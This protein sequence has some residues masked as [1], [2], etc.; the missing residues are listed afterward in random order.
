MESLLKPLEAS[1]LITSMR[2]ANDGRPGYDFCTDTGLTICYD[3][4]IRPGTLGGPDHRLPETGV[5]CAHQN[6]A[7][8]AF[9]G[10]LL[11][12]I[13]C[14][15]NDDDPIGMLHWPAGLCWCGEFHRDQAAALEFD[16]WR[17][18]MS[19]FGPRPQLLG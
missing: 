12:S 4:I 5:V 17:R 14:Q 6:H 3:C 18:A 7:A 9:A 8:P 11:E 2:C 1:T 19:T 13:R 15:P 16:P 10:G